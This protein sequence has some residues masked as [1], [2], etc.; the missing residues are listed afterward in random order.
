MLRAFHQV[1][2]LARGT[3]AD[4]AH[5]GPEPGRAEGGQGEEAARV[6]SVMAALAASGQIEPAGAANAIDVQQIIK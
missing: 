4:H 5:G 6:V 2:Q 1:R 3:Q